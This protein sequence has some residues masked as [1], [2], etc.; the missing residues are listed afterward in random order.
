MVSHP[1]L[2]NVAVFQVGSRFIS[3]CHMLHESTLKVGSKVKAG[4]T[5][6]FAGTT[7]SASN[8]VHLHGV[9]GDTIDSAVSGQVSDL[10]AFLVSK[11]AEEKKVK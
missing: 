11:I 7:G 1:A 9:L 8:G 10:H 4:D 2:G 5:I 3:Y 6:G